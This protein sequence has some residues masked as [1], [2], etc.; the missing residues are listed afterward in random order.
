MSISKTTLTYKRIILSMIIFFIIPLLFPV[1]NYFLNDETITYTCLINVFT[2]ILMIYD[3][4]LVALH[5]NRI[6]KNFKECLLYDLVGIIIFALIFVFNH[7]LLHGSFLTIDPHI[8]KKYYG[9]A[10]LMLFAYCLMLPIAMSICYKCLTDRLNIKS[11]ELMVI[12]FSGLF[13]GLLF[14]IAFVPYDINLW[15]RSYIL[16]ALITSVLSYIYN[17]ST[18]FLVSALSL[19]TVLLVY[20]LIIILL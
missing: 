9:G 18:S 12:L 17:H 13:F 16:N 1:L 6:K 11:Q 4:N 3:Y 15:I 8:F 19:A 5:Y 7:F 14:T 20:N 2:A 10:I